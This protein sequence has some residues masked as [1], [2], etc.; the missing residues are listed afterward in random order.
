MTALLPVLAACG[1]DG[2][3]ATGTTPVTTDVSVQI[4]DTGNPRADAGTIAFEVTPTWN[5]SDPTNVVLLTAGSPDQTSDQLKVFKSGT[6]LQSL[7]VN[8]AGQEYAIGISI[9]SWKA[10]ELHAITLTWENG[11]EQLYVDGQLGGQLYYQ[12][13]FLRPGTPLYLGSQLPPGV[14]GASGAI[15]DVHA[16]GRPLTPEEIATLFESGTPVASPTPIAPGTSVALRVLST[17]VAEPDSAGTVCVELVG[18]TG[19]VAGTQNDLGWDPGCMEINEPCEANPQHGKGVYTG[20][21]GG[22]PLRTLVFSLTNTD[23]IDDGVLYCCPFHIASLRSGTC[24]AVRVQGAYASDSVG[25]GVVTEGVD[26]QIC[27][28]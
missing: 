17:T 20:Q 7:F 2:G 16:Y 10:G 23:P 21:R 25:H 8:S 26:G 6:Y 1:G 4:P 11:I 22:P 14:P 15:T 18:G 19:F 28:R 27:L 3:A 13:A 5:G 24:C 12:G 9:D